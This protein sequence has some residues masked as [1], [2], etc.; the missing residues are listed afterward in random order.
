MAFIQ[1]VSDLHLETHPSYKDFEIPAT[2]QYL[3]LLG[4]IGHICD[5]A[6]LE[7]LEDLL[8][9]YETVFFLLGNHEPYHMRFSSAKSRMK[10]FAVKMDRLRV[11]SCVGR[12]VLLDQ[13]RYDIPGVSGG[14]VTILGCTLFSRVAHDQVKEVADRFVDFKDIINWDVGDHNDSHQADVEW[15]NKE[16]EKISVESPQR[17]IIIFT[18]YSPSIDQRTKN[19]RY[20]KSTVDSGFMTDLS[21][22]ICWRSPNVKLWAFGH[23][24]YNVDFTDENTGKRVL[25]NQKGYY[26]KLP[27]SKNDRDGT[28]FRVVKTINIRSL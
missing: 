1:I 21:G 15:L 9:R 3:A 25:A 14:S 2:A 16:V 23:T 27:P 19:P 17:K 8:G 13:T 10:K 11:N 6:F 5:E 4:D 26:A 18:H 24:H 28:P 20:L 12:F 7:W 22:Q